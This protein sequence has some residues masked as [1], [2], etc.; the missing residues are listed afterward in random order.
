MARFAGRRVQL[1]IGLETTRGTA[2]APTYWY[3]FLDA[4]IVDKDSPLFNESSFGHIMKNSAKT[5][6][7]VNGE[8][9]VTGKLYAKGLYF[10]LALVFGQLPTTTP[11]SG[12]DT[13]ANAHVFSVLNT[14]EHISA[15]VSTKTPNEDLRFAL[16]MLESLTLTW[17]PDAYPQIEAAFVSKSGVAATNTVAL[18]ADSE[19][20]PKHASMKLASTVAGLTSA[21]ALTDVKSFSIT[22]TKTLAPQQTMDSGTTYGQI[23]NTDFEVTGSIE[24][25][26]NDVTY[27]GYTLQDSVQAMRFALV[28]SVNKA[29][30]TT[31]TSLS[32]D[33]SKVVFDS[34]VPQYGKSDIATE[35]LNFTA[36][37]DQANFAQTVQ[38]TLVNKYMYP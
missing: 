33:M 32:F 14:N 12:G 31:P 15:T 3:P 7:L 4:S 26:L 25:L 35:T 10:F 11:N 19:F 21:A 38:A 27:K 36:I 8:G 24:K 30:A 16:A 5:T 18:A 9:N 13:G 34:H 6:T 17:A 1:G 2:V 28:D 29:G 20:L 22:F 37:L 23:F